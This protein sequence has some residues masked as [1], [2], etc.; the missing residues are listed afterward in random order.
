M[1]ELGTVKFRKMAD[2][3]AEDW[4]LITEHHETFHGPRLADR[5]IALLHDL[6]GPKLG[7]QIDRFDHSLQTATR[8]VR[9]GADEETVVVALLHDIGDNLA[10]ENHCEVAAGILR[11]YVSDENCWLTLNH[12]IF[13]GYYF[14]HLTGLDRNEHL[15]LRGH[16]AYAKTRRFVEDWDGTSFDPDYDALPFATFEPMVRRLFARTPRSQWRPTE[17]RSA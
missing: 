4:A 14:F 7:F 13:S 11:P 2:N 17:L 10:P 3:T 15:E 9:D 16:P 5:V 6:K 1:A 8:A 12:V